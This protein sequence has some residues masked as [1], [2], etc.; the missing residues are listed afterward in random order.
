MLTT[1]DKELSS[2]EE[3]RWSRIVSDESKSTKDSRVTRRN[4]QHNSKQDQKIQNRVRKGEN[5]DGHYTIRLR[6]IPVWLRLVIIFVVSVVAAFVGAY[7]GYVILGDGKP[8]EVL[9]P[10]TWKHIFDLVNKAK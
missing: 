1:Q 6:L 8:S 5:T 7:F 4:Y 3:S 10:S 9:S 2:K